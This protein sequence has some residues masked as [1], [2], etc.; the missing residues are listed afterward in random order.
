MHCCVTA[1]CQLKKYQNLEVLGVLSARTAFKGPRDKLEPVTR[2]ILCIGRVLPY[3]V[4][5]WRHILLPNSS[6]LSSD[7]SKA[8][9]SRGRRLR[10]GQLSWRGCRER[11]KAKKSKYD[12][13]YVCPFLEVNFTGSGYFAANNSELYSCM[14]FV[15]TIYI[16][17]SPAEIVKTHLWPR[18]KA[19]D[20]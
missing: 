8:I 3:S 6:K 10:R 11:R 15:H 7:W 4:F 19:S 9:M 17:M 20:L 12:S 1:V 18:G 16:Y 2:L 13:S 14:K 5:G